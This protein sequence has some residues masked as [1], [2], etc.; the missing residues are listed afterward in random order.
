MK[1]QGGKV[2]RDATGEPDG[3]L[4]EE[5]MK[6]RTARILVTLPQDVRQVS[7]ILAGCIDQRCPEG[8]R[9]H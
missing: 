1:A 7:R 2:R 8:Q 6:E 4:E 3:V 5:A 9:H